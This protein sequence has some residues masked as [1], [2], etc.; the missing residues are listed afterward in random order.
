MKVFPCLSG[1]DQK[2]Q[3]QSEGSEHKGE[4]QTWQKD[5]AIDLILPGIVD[6]IKTGHQVE[7]EIMDPP[8]E[9][10]CLVCKKLH[11]PLQGAEAV[12]VSR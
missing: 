11:N 1:S 6:D 7:G 4:Y 12:E 10:A 5:P 3:Q 8:C 2:V 9:N